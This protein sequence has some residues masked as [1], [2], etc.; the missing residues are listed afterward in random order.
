M[1][2]LLK[3]LCWLNVLHWLR[4]LCIK[5]YRYLFTY[6]FKKLFLEENSKASFSFCAPV[7]TAY[8]GLQAGSI[9][10]YRTPSFKATDCTLFSFN[11][12]DILVFIDNLK[13]LVFLFHNESAYTELPL[14]LANDVRVS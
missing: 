8:F 11:L 3:M 4:M 10:N 14:F 6:C 12:I 7:N 5:N 2:C 13:L 1:F 9:L